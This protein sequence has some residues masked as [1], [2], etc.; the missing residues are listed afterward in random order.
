MSDA[1]PISLSN[2]SIFYLIFLSIPV[3]VFAEL[4]CLQIDSSCPDLVYVCLY[5]VNPFQD[6]SLL[7]LLFT[8][9]ININVYTYISQMNGSKLKEVHYNSGYD[10][11]YQFQFSPL[12]S[13]LQFINSI[14]RRPLCFI[15]FAGLVSVYIVRSTAIKI[16][17][18]YALAKSSREQLSL[19]SMINFRRRR[20]KKIK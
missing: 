17:F 11:I 2:L 6:C 20:R 16:P 15:L 9:Y 18:I 19:T 14:S 10:C 7:N 8:I 5:L 1:P 4:Q 3:S 13:M 12:S